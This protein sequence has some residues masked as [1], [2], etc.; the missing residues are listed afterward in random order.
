LVRNA[1]LFVNHF[2]QSH[3]NQ[4]HNWNELNHQHFHGHHF[5][6]SWFHGMLNSSMVQHLVMWDCLQSRL[7]LGM[8]YLWLNMIFR[9]I[10]FIIN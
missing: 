5:N 3:L 10:L 6:Q 9:L 8:G 7:N 2:H 4:I 1:F